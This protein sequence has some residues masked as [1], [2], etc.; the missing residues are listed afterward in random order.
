M[1]YKSCS[2]VLVW[3][4]LI[5]DCLAECPA[6]SSCQHNG[7]RPLL[8]R[9]WQK[10]PGARRRSLKICAK[11]AV[12]RA[13]ITV[14][15]RPKDG[16]SEDSR[17]SSMRLRH[18]FIGKTCHKKRHE[19]SEAISESYEHHLDIPRPMWANM[20]IFPAPRNPA[21]SLR[22]PRGRSW[23]GTVAAW[24]GLGI[25]PSSSSRR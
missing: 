16:M 20:F 12:L 6:V 24:V 10:W 25:D 8:Q 2:F 22:H 7:C 15:K 11:G 17:N 9:S 3:R 19:R 1:L 5:A 4:N 13:C 21:V 14:S 23:C 18:L